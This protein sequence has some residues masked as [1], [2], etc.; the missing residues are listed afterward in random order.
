M[1]ID[2]LLEVS[3]AK[4]ASDL[5]ILPGL[6]PMV[7]VDGILAPIKDAAILSADDT[8][9]LLFSIM[10]D[11]QK[12]TFEHDLVL[13]LGL[14][15]ALGNF[16][17]SIYHQMHGV[18]AVFRVIPQKI[19]SFDELELPPVLK[20]LLLMTRGL[21]LAAGPTGSGKST[22]LAA[23]I[24]YINTYRIC[25]IF[26]IEDPIEFVYTNKRSMFNQVQVGRDAVDFANALRSSLRQ[27]PNVIMLGE[28]RDLETMRLALTAV[29]T[30]HLVLATIHAS[31]APLAVSRFADVFPTEEKNRVRVLLSET[32]EA[33]ICQRL[34]RKSAGGRIGVFEVMTSSSSIR[35]FIRQDM[36]AHMESAIQTS[37]DKGMITFEVALNNLVQ[38]R[39][40]TQMI[41]SSVLNELKSSSDSSRSE[42]G[43]GG[44]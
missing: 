31:S 16:R 25:N 13:E 41:A 4:R 36:P 24:D 28:L 22:S 7:R 1:N 2:Q 20:S 42:S 32:L 37:G 21:I 39:I 10:T 30:G 6:A 38:K 15:N 40:I 26:T 18:A 44:R 33:V 3:V 12:Q 11:D 29:E 35:H 17:V 34:I 9:Q 19:P 8:R 27:D 43:N 5:H 23:M 14:F